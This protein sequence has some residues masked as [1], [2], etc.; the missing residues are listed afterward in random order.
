[1]TGIKNNNK[2]KC[3]PVI[4]LIHQD[5]VQYYFTLTSWNRFIKMFLF[6]CSR[7]EWRLC[8][9][10]LILGPEYNRQFWFHL[11]YSQ[12]SNYLTALGLRAWKSNSILIYRRPGF[13][14]HISD[15]AID[16]NAIY[17]EYNSYIILYIYIFVYIYFV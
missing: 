2:R 5:I 15:Q 8:Y 9:V 14:L 13:Y 10:Y 12:C 1:M 4:S 17:H 11:I 6:E 7:L 16:M 3:R